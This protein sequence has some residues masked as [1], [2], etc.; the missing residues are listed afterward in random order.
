MKTRNGEPNDVCQGRPC[1]AQCDPSGVNEDAQITGWD[2]ARPVAAGRREQTYIR[3]THS[4]YEDDAPSRGPEGS[5]LPLYAR[6]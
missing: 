5:R 3:P 2:I 1:L 6:V 4:N